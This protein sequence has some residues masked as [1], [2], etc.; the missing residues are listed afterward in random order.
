MPSGRSASVCNP[1]RTSRLR[2]VVPVARA[3]MAS[4]LAHSRRTPWRRPPPAE[5]VPA[6]PLHLVDRL[7]DP[8]VAGAPAQVAADRLADLQLVRVR[9]AVQQIVDGDDQPRDAES[10]L[11]GT[12]VEERLLDVGEVL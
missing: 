9:D 6:L 3:F 10:A 7:E 2:V 12:G 5:L 11:H 8:P 4:P 1:S